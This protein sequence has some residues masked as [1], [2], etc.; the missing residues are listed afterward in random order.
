MI[1]GT[2]GTNLIEIPC[3]IVLLV[4]AISIKKKVFKMLGCDE[5][6]FKFV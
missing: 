2:C 4:H 5:D 1:D 3:S 6:Y